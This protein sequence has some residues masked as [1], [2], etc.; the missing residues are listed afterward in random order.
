MKPMRGLVG[1]AVSALV[2]LVAAPAAAV[3]PQA[4]SN[5]SYRIEGLM[6]DGSW[7]YDGEPAAGQLMA[8]GVFGADGVET[9]RVTRGR[10]EQVPMASGVAF[11]MMRQDADTGMLYPVEVWGIPTEVDF[12]M[13]GDL[14]AATLVFQ[15]EAEVFAIDP[16][17][18]EETPTGE[19]LA[20]S[21]Q[22]SWV[23]DGPVTTVKSHGKYIDETA[24]TIDN[25]R[26]TSRAAQAHLTLIG[27]DGPIFDEML[28]SG[29]LMDVRAATIT[30]YWP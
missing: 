12:E 7:W 15:V 14:S 22:A 1:L 6:A 3:M 23:G 9:V 10:P 29:S 24:F 16:D 2:A 28:S 11:A 21:V 25:A 8:V 20:L 18:G 5:E 17:T 19:T 13:A 4:A 30:H 26:M 27:P